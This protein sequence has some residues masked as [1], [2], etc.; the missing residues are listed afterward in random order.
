M[1]GR[2]KMVRNFASLLVD[3]DTP[4]IIIPIILGGEKL[5]FQYY[6]IK[7]SNGSYPCKWTIVPCYFDQCFAA[8]FVICKRS[9]VPHSGLIRKKLIKTTA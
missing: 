3:I 2:K 5:Q 4:G 1:D 8:T 7:F 6:I 9:D